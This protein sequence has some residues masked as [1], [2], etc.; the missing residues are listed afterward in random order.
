MAEG[1]LTVA[2]PGQ[3]LQAANPVLTATYQAVPEPSSPDQDTPP[4]QDQGNHISAIAQQR[5]H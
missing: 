4:H 3:V 5:P 2:A 1:M